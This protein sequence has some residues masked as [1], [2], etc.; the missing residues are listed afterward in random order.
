MEFRTKGNY[1]GDIFTLSTSEESETRGCHLKASI[2]RFQLIRAFY[3]SIKEFSLSP[4]YDPSEWESIDIATRLLDFLGVEWNPDRIVNTLATFNGTQLRHF[5][6]AVC[7]DA[8]NNSKVCTYEI[9]K[10]L[11][12]PDT[13]P[14]FQLSAENEYSW[15]IENAYDSSDDTQRL[16]LIREYLSEKI[17]SWFGLPLKKLRSDIIETR[18]LS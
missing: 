16:A 7:D 3:N 17:Y 11:K 8:R 10:Y 2:D 5:I 1:A 4:A 12:N 18:V 15:Y 9:E 14:I 13:V 6:L